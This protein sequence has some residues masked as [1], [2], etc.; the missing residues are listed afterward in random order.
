LP[1]ACCRVLQSVDNHIVIVFLSIS[2]KIYK[3]YTLWPICSDLCAG[4]PYVVTPAAVA[5]D[6]VGF[7][8]KGVHGDIIGQEGGGLP[9]LS[10]QIFFMDVVLMDC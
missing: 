2:R 10:G 9:P 1:A 3:K 6:P 4:S 5:D 8:G 7:P